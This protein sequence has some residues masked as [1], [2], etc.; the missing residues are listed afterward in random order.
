MPKRQ[1]IQTPIDVLKPYQRNA[2]T[3]SKAQIEQIAKSIETFGF[4]NPVLIEEQ[5]LPHLIT[6]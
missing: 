3:H 1:I 4:T 5:D 2:R 6:T